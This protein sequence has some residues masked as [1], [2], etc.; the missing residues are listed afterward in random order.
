MIDVLIPVFNARTTVH[1]AVLTILRQSVGDLRVIL[2]DDGSFD[3]TS[4][5]L[6]ELASSDSRILLVRKEN[7]GI[8]SALNLGLSHCRA[9]FIARHDADD[10]A[11]PNR[12]ATQLDYLR[13]N[14]D[15]VA[16]GANAWHIDVH[17]RHI[18]RTRLFGEPPADW[19]VVP[20]VEPY[21]MHPFLLARRWA[22]EKA[23]GYR[24]VYNAEDTDLYWRLREEGRLH[25]LPDLLGEYRIHA[26][27]V[28]SGSAVSARINAATSQLAAISARRSRAGV[29]DLEFRAD[30]LARYRE[31]GDFRS[32][33]A[34][35]TEQLTPDEARWLRI[36]A[37]AKLLELRSY[38]AFRLSWDD[39]STITSIFLRG[40][41]R[42]S[43]RDRFN[44]AHK[45]AHRLRPKFGIKR[46][47]ARITARS[48]L[49][50]G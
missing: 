27:G 25:N 35:A 10:I 3:G 9:E 26:G 38:R 15:C 45:V 22:I 13:A 11:Y 31:G 40:I 19:G 17:G 28:T 20:S 29:A 6:A 34:I 41:G 18:G 5:I 44:V 21:M 16:V 24:E 2:V 50:R 39:I 1:D 7:G 43:P 4:E 49:S 30:T 12:L 36:A 47:I 23:G 48:A 46:M 42:M 33:L 32:V 8:V 14:A 37:A